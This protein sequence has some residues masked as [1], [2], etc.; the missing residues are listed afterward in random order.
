MHRGK[1]KKKVAVIEI[2]KEPKVKIKENKED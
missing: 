1:K 2:K